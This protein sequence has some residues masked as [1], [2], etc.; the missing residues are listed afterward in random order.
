MLDLVDHIPSAWRV[1]LASHRD[2]IVRIDKALSELIDTGAQVM[3][4]PERIFSALEIEPEQVRVVVIGQDPYPTPGMAIGRAFAVEEGSARI[5]GSLRNI[6]KERRDDVGGPDPSV[7]LIQWQ[8]QGV[9]LLNRTLTVEVGKAGSH[10]SLGWQRIT[11]AIA[12]VAAEN[13]AIGLL[14]GKHAGEMAGIFTRGY[15]SGVHPSPLS[16]HRG[17]FGSRPFSKANLLLDHP[18]SW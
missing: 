11:E 4:S 6:L 5:P 14:W 17:F 1:V 16:A 7:S 15:V 12:K 3:P 8:E 18:I 2:Q 13:G 10:V 9:L